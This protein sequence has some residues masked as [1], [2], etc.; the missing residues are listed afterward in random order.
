MSVHRRGEGTTP[1]V[2]RGWHQTR[3]LPS[4]HDDFTAKGEFADRSVSVRECKAPFGRARLLSSRSLLSVFTCRCSPTTVD[5]LFLP[6][7]LVPTQSRDAA[8]VAPSVFGCGFPWAL[9]RA[10]L[11]M[12]VGQM[13]CGGAPDSGMRAGLSANHPSGL[14]WKIRTAQTK[15]TPQRTCDRTGFVGNDKASALVVH[16]V[17][18]PQ[19]RA[20]SVS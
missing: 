14:N 8:H 2:R 11:T 20:V 15:Y 17:Q 4:T 10:M 1:T 18:A 16:R 7:R 19:R 5:R 13:W 12:A 9:P 3:D 6:G